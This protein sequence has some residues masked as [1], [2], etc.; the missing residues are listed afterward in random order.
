MHHGS[1]F[2]RGSLYIT[3]LMS[4]GCRGLIYLSSGSVQQCDCCVPLRALCLAW[5]WYKCNIKNIH[6]QPMLY[7]KLQE[8]SSVYL[9]CLARWFS[10]ENAD[11]V[12]GSLWVIELTLKNGIVEP[13]LV[14]MPATHQLSVHPLLPLRIF[15]AIPA[16]FE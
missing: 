8:F 4:G 14:S 2:I 11:L 6:S 9:L 3:L 5:R 1:R 10:P 12:V 13:L 15:I 16:A 7:K